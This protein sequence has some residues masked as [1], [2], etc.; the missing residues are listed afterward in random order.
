MQFL[1]EL[2]Q[3]IFFFD[4]ALIT[5]GRRNPAWG[6]SD[7]T[8]IDLP[9]KE[10][11][12]AWCETYKEKVMQAK[13]EDIRYEKI[14]KG[15]RMA[16]ANALRNRYTVQVYEATN[17]LQHYPTRLLLALQAYDE[18]QG[19]ANRQ[20]ALRNIADVCEDFETMRTHFLS[21]YSQT[22]FMEQPEGYIADLNHH[23][24]LASK[25]NNSDWWFYYEIPMIKKVRSWLKL[26]H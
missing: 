22:R 18:A 20:E 25:T 23:N 3:A 21:V 6:V 7:F 5:S 11:P 8:L 16:E 19:E 13:Q 24:H 17:E 12:G 14:K 4:N 9:E 10:N 2:E 1:D 15:I 26:E